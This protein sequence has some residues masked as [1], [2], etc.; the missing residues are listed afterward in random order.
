MG[1]KQWGL[2]KGCLLMAWSRGSKT[3]NTEFRRPTKL[4]LTPP[5]HERRRLKL[6]NQRS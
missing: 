2:R 1:E 4:G 6:M 3:S 5:Y